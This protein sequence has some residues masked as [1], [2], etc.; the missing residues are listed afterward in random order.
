MHLVINFFLLAANIGFFLTN[1][2]LGCTRI[3]RIHTFLGMVKVQLKIKVK[4][5]FTL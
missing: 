3:C 5:T 4:V 1:D 2:F